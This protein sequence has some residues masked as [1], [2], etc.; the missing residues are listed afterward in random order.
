MSTWEEGMRLAVKRRRCQEEKRHERMTHHHPTLYDY[1]PVRYHLPFILPYV[2]RRL[3]LQ[4]VWI[5]AMVI[6]AALSFSSPPIRPAS[7]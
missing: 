6:R 7:Q 5:H 1:A 2:R 3:T 4:A